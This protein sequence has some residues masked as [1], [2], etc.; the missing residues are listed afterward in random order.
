[1]RKSSQQIRDQLPLIQDQEPSRVIQNDTGLT[2]TLGPGLR[3]ID[4]AYVNDEQAFAQLD[5]DGDFDQ[6]GAE[7]DPLYEEPAAR[8]QAPA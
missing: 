8:V 4:A 7:P 3:L 1:M 5:I 2:R 6:L